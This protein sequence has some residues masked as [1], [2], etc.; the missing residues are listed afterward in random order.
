MSPTNRALPSTLICGCPSAAMLRMRRPLQYSP[1]SCPWNMPA[2]RSPPPTRTVVWLLKIVSWRP[3][4]HAHTKETQPQ[5]EKRWTDTHTHTHT[6]QRSHMCVHLHTNVFECYTIHHPKAW[7]EDEI[8]KAWQSGSKLWRTS[9]R[10][11]IKKLEKE[12][13]RGGR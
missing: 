8:D 6:Y 7:Q 13:E 2:L 12:E 11:Q 3:N 1:E 5:Q 9:S 4:A 10:F